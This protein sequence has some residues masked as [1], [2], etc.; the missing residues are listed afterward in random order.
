MDSLDALLTAMELATD[1][2]ARDAAVDR[3]VAFCERHRG[4][5]IMIFVPADIHERFRRISHL[6]DTRLQNS[7]SDR[8]EVD[9]AHGRE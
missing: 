5:G 3:L 1:Q 2:E 8:A 6:V 9:S 7:N 4:T